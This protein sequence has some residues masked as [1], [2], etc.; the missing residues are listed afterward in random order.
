M[1]RTILLP[2]KV[3]TGKKKHCKLKIFFTRFVLKF[4]ILKL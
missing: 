1:I 3:M 2:E 4:K